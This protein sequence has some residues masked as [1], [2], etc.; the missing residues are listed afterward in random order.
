MPIERSQSE[1]TMY[2]DSN[3]MLFQKM[4]QWRWWK[5]WWFPGTQRQEEEKGQMNH[6]GPLGY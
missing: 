5:D 2:C 3:Y 6:R 4:K 1:K